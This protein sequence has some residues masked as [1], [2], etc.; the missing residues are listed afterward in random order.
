MSIL[1]LFWEF[2][3]AGLLSFGGL[4]SLPI[5]VQSLIHTHGWATEAQFGQAHARTCRGLGHGY[6]YMQL[7]PGAAGR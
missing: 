2:L 5:L 3:K 4:G 1:A 6:E 7:D